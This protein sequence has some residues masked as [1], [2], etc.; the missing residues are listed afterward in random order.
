M[1]FVPEQWI[2]DNE[3]FLTLDS[4]CITLAFGILIG[5]VSECSSAKK[6][7]LINVPQ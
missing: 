5:L 6:K 2:T 1:C 7:F 3:Y 4:E